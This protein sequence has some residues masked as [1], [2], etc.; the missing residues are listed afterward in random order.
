MKVCKQK[1]VGRD[2]GRGL[3]G[4]LPMILTHFRH[5]WLLL[6]CGAFFRL[7][8]AVSCSLGFGLLLG[9]D[10]ESERAKAYALPGSSLPSCSKV[11]TYRTQ[12]PLLRMCR[13]ELSMLLHGIPPLCTITGSPDL[14]LQGSPSTSSKH[15]G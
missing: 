13:N 1:A 6:V 5:T 3:C 15:G 2:A 8:S 4:T 10:R 7:A 12:C 11:G 9:C 14:T